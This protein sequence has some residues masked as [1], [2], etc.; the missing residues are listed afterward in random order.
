M[1]LKQLHM[2][3][4]ETYGLEDIFKCVADGSEKKKFGEDI[5]KLASD[6]IE[7]FFHKGVKCVCCDV[8]G[9]FFAKERHMLPI[10][11]GKGRGK[12][13]VGYK[14]D[15]GT[16]YHFN[17]YGVNEDGKEVL[18]TKDHIIPKSHGGKNNLSNYQTMC[19]KCNERKGSDLLVTV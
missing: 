1:A 6:R 2:E 5:I 14:L 19:K 13:I 17:L 7:T 4:K 11:K 12:R 8:E 18:M 9:T 10:K 3:R 15:V 16:S